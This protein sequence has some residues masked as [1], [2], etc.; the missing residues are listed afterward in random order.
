VSGPFTDEVLDALT[1]CAGRIHAVVLSTP[2]SPVPK[3][4]RDSMAP[5]LEGVRLLLGAVIL[6]DSTVSL[7]DAEEAGRAAILAAAIPARGAS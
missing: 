1:A 7:H 4:V 3:E 6:S 5:I 2:Q